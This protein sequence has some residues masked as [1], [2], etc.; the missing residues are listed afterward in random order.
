MTYTREMSLRAALRTGIRQVNK[1][2]R[3]VFWIL[4]ANFLLALIPTSL[5]S[6]AIEDSLGE[7]LMAERLANGYDDIWF[8]EFSADA[9]D[10]AS[11]F[12][13]TTAGW[14]ALLDSFDRFFTGQLFG[15]NSALFAFGVMYA[16][17]WT[18]LSGGIFRAFKK[19]IP[20]TLAEFANDSADLFWRFLRLAFLVGIG[21]WVVY[22]QV[23]PRLG[24]LVE[25]LNRET[26]DERVDFL[27][28]LAATALVLLLLAVLNLTSDYAKSLMVLESRR[29][30][31]LVAA[32][33]LGLAIK[34]PVKVLGL[35]GALVLIGILFFL[36]YS[37][38][39][40]GVGQ[41]SWLG[42]LAALL[43]GQL[44]IASRIWTRMLFYASQ[45]EL[46][47]AL[48]TAPEPSRV[49]AVSSTPGTPGSTSAGP[50]PIEQPQ[51]PEEPIA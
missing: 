23:G 3:V 47:R 24:N 39:A 8:R 12:H 5:I 17:L 22:Q 11:T 26:I 30:S 20:S 45:M 38:A 1:N 13:P 19:G 32:K 16:I 43:V 28:N 2:R 37:A 44:Y 36:I 49:E 35:Y 18:F 29:S 15:I 51:D 4:V 42:V 40:P 25:T 6:I 14:G 10:L 7:S 50:M 31:L 27:W 41:S 46:C 9:G 48:T 33:A 21:Y 34:N